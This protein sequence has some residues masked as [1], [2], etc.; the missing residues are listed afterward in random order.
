MGKNI[1]R[2]RFSIVTPSLNQIEWLKLCIASVADQK[3]VEVE[4]I[5][6]DACSDDGTSE[7]LISDKRVKAFIEKDKGM[8]DA[9]NRGFSRSSGD[10]FAYLNCDEQYL[11]GALKRVEDYF[12]Y[13]PDIDVLFAST[14]VVDKLGRLICYRKAI[15]PTRNVILVDHLP[16]FTCSTFFRRKVI[17]EYGLKYDS[18]LRSVADCYWILEMIYKKI[19]FSAVHFYT[20][21]FT[22]T[23]ENM[24]LEEK[25]RREYSD[26]Q[27]KA[28]IFQK[29]FKKGILIIHRLKKAL[30]GHYFEKS[31]NYKLYTQDSL[32]QRKS[33]QVNN[34][35]GIWK[36]RLGISNII[37][38][39][40]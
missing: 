12:S 4:H 7:W 37:K 31:L 19:Y 15:K 23:G 26:L 5:V 14:L 29:K 17:D 3:D 28:H 2:A 22:D 9:V 16:T 27:K 21:A 39:L 40:H 25:T 11:P 36:N 10:I 18:K 13:N 20:S 33:F 24:N 32:D 1:N 38:I 34:P 35:T 6:Q 30:T 8:Y